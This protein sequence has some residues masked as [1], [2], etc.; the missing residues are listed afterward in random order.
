MHI[1]RFVA[2]DWSGAL[3]QVRE[4]LGPDALV[5]SSREVRKR[6]RAFG[7]MARPQVEIVAAVDR[8]R[9]PDRRTSSPVPS[10]ASPRQAAAASE[11]QTG[12]GADP[13]WRGLQLSRS[14]LEPIESE[15]RFLRASVE[16]VRASR[17]EGEQLREE[18]HA[19]RRS[20]RQL[21]EAQSR[22][23]EDGT[24]AT[25]LRAAGLSDVH[26]DSLAQEASERCRRTGGPELDHV[27]RVLTARIDGALAPPRPDREAPVRL[28]VGA[29]GAGKT[30]TIAKCAGRFGREVPLALISADVSRMGADAPLRGFARRLDVPFH[31]A[32]D[33]QALAQQIRRRDGRQ[34]WIDTPGFARRD[35][36]ALGELQALRK[37]VGERARIE[38]VVS[39]TT[40][41]ADLR[42]EIGRHRAL[43]PDA[44]VVT[45]WDESDDISNVVNLLLDSNTPPISWLGTGQAVPGDLA[46]PD[47]GE[48]AGRLLG[49]LP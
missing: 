18:I 32:A 20:I 6:T 44:L 35:P 34:L 25:R 48:L 47:P 37:A 5:L 16:S 28:V 38:L 31:R 2:A 43:E 39:A 14:L 42:A 12:V 21:A 29:P 49:G 33:R 11:G 24:L 17:E 13:S 46:V 15:V 10:V 7:L 26:A 19:L 36:E 40:R 45:R 22:D 3:A 8:D 41:E 27:R 1:K 4:E 23:R 30:T 9:N